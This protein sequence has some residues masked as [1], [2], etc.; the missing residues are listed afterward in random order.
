MLSVCFNVFKM[1]HGPFIQSAD[2]KQLE[3]EFQ[4]IKDSAK[5]AAQD[6]KKFLRM[7]MGTGMY[8]KS[9]RLKAQFQ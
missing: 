3:R 4:L 2:R 8:T 7:A 1:T 6:R 5:E 9:G